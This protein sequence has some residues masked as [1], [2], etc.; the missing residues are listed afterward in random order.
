MS[1]KKLN[2]E[3]WEIFKG[4]FKKY[5]G[6][7]SIP[8]ASENDFGLVKIGRGLY[9]DDT[10]KLNV[11]YSVD[12][13]SGDIYL[14]EQPNNIIQ[15]KPDGLFAELNIASPEEVKNAVSKLFSL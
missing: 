4:L 3:N 5:V 6:S 7:N 15:L 12:T 1:Y 9:I 13:G 14:S 10:G 11:S 8:I 2:Q